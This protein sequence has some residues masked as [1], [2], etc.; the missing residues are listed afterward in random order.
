M[1]QIKNFIE[2]HKAYPRNFLERGRLKVEVFNDNHEPI[3]PHIKNS[4]RSILLQEKYF[5]KKQART[6][7]RLE[8]NDEF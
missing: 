4:K 3:H 1:C 6:Y 8:K 7:K 5:I 2:P